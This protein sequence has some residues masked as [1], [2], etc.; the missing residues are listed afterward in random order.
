ME[1]SHCKPYNK[2]MQYM[3]CSTIFLLL[4]VS[5]VASGLVSFASENRGSGSKVGSYSDGYELGKI[6]GRDS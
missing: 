3:V 1:I 6:N 2:K 4:V 5:M